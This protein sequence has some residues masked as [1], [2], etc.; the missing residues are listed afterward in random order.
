ME[1]QPCDGHIDPCLPHIDGDRCEGA[2]SQA[3]SAQADRYV[4]SSRTIP[5]APERRQA[6][7]GVQINTPATRGGPLESPS[8]RSTSR[9]ARRWPPCWFARESG[10]R[11]R[12]ARWHRSRPGRVGVEARLTDEPAMVVGSQGGGA[13][14][15][16]H[17]QAGP[18]PRDAPADRHRP[19]TLRARPRCPWWCRRV[20]SAHE[21][22]RVASG[23]AATLPA[24]RWLVRGEP[25]LPGGRWGDGCLEQ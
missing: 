19:R 9:P 5:V 7:H 25:I 4:V 14:V 12:G 17:G 21:R 13:A 2:S 18:G 20:M 15:R 11:R 16:R 24:S 23:K 22:R 10:C 6:C 3:V 1:R 8:P